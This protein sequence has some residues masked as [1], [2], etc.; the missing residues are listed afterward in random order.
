MRTTVASSRTATVRPT[1]SWLTVAIGEPP[2]A[3]KTAIM[4]AAAPV[5]TRAV[6]SRPKAIAAALSPLAVVV[7]AHPH[8]QE[9]RVVD[10]EAEDDAED[11]RRPDRVDVGVAA[12]RPAVGHVGEQG[13]DA[14]SDA[15]GRQVEADRE[16]RQRQRPQDDDQD[17]EGGEA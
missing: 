13:E 12:E 6:F 15:D 5:I 9:D 1:P 10:R 7:L 14:E 8:Q 3:T 17:E 4:I 11:H 2:K 16:R